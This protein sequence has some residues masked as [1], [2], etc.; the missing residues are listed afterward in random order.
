M[1]V[2]FLVKTINNVR[3]IFTA[4]TKTKAIEAEKLRLLTLQNLQRQYSLQLLEKEYL[5]GKKTTGTLTSA[6]KKQ[7]ANLDG[8]IDL[9]KKDIDA[10][11]SVAGAAG[12]A[13]GKRVGKQQST[14]SKAQSAMMIIAGAAAVISL[15]ADSV[16][17]IQ[18]AA[19]EAAQEVLGKNTEL[20]AEIYENTQVIG[21]I[22]KLTSSFKELDDKLIKTS[23][24]WDEIEN[25]RQ[26]LLEQFKAEERQS[27]ENMRVEELA[28]LAEGRAT[29]LEAENVKKLTEMEENMKK[30][31]GTANWG[32]NIAAGAGAGLGLG[33]AIGMAGGPAAAAIGAGI[34]AAAGAVAGLGVSIAEQIEKSNAKK[35]LKE[36]LKSEEGLAQA[37]YLYS[38]QMKNLTSEY[39]IQGERIRSIYEGLLQTLDAKEFEQ[40]LIDSGLTA[41][42]YAANM[43]KILK[44]NYAQVSALTDSSTSYSDKIEALNVLLS[45]DMPA[46]MKDGLKLMYGELLDLTNQFPTSIKYLDQFGWSL[47]QLNKFVTALDKEGLDPD[48][49]MNTIGTVLNSTGTVEDKLALLGGSMKGLS[50]DAISAIADLIAAG[51]TL[52]SV[53]EEQTATSS[54]IKN[55]RSTQGKWGSMSATEQSSFISE[56][57]GLFMTNGEWDD[58]KFQRFIQ[59]MDISG[60]LTDYMNEE[61]A[62]VIKD[63]EDVLLSLNLELQAQQKALLDPE[64]TEEDIAII[65]KQIE[66]LKGEIAATTYL[67]E[68]AENMFDLTLDEMVKQQQ[69]QISLYKD[70]LE[71]ERDALIESLEERKDAYNDYFDAINKQYETQ[72]YEEQK[73]KLE[74]QILK[75]SGATDAASM[76]KVAELQSQLLDLEKGRAETLRQDAQNAVLES[77]DTQIEDANEYYDKRL[78]NDAAMLAEMSNQLEVDKATYEL[79]YWNY[80]QTLGLSEE[81]KQQRFEEFQTT[82]SGGIAGSGTP[83]IPTIS[84]PNPNSVIVP[85]TENNYSFNI[86]G[87]NVDFTK[88]ETAALNELLRAALKRIGINLS[89]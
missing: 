59:G 52:Q 45:S 24:D 35:V 47:D 43:A 17:R 55:I 3:E 68:E 84:T 4:L 86:N 75:L 70:M 62:K 69:A 77:I 82:F 20:Q 33:A 66:A 63:Y 11:D 76:M 5:L 53:S 48:K 15:L 6:E 37:R 22:K 78:E 30:A 50:A 13:E 80:L 1:L 81:A 8:Q 71:S 64:S 38:Q 18:N 41:A 44:T 72:D 10:S 73:A 39:G 58:E 26:Q 49:W 85:Q 31:S 87:R 79:Q 32:M 51:R 2:P 28:A 54:R 60:M 14:A 42:E 23:K 29:E 89:I 88:A 34:G 57:M 9:T 16:K 74:A 65:E 27:M 25:I 12:T 83:Y 67:A 40:I 46:E 56:N 36:M 7:L 61:Q 19:A 21:N